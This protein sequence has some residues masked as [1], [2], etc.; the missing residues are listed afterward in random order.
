MCFFFFAEMEM[1][2]QRSLF[3]MESKGFSANYNEMFALSE[4]LLEIMKR[5][6]STIYKMNC[7]KFN[8]A[9]S[10]EVANVLGMRYKASTSKAAL[11]KMADPMSDLIMQWRKLSG[12][13]SKTVRPLLQC[14]QNNRYKK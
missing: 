13:L 9:S 4:Q 7:R 1:P 11:T 6:E 5:L 8:I 10:V 14:I 2:I 12:T 3:L